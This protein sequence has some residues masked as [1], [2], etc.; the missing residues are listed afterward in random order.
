MFDC[1]PSSLGPRHRHC[2]KFPLATC[3]WAN[4]VQAGGRWLSVKYFMELYR[5]ICPSYCVMLLTMH[6]TFLRN[7]CT[8]NNSSMYVTTFNCR[9]LLLGPHYRHCC[10]FSLAACIWANRDDDEAGGH[11]L[12]NSWCDICPTNCSCCWLTSHQQ[13]CP[14]VAL[15][16]VV[17]TFVHHVSSLSQTGHLLQPDSCSGSLSDYITAASL[18]PLFHYKL[19]RT[20]FDSHT[21]TLLLHH[22]C[23]LTFLSNLGHYK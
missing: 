18:L 8:V 1:L 17:L 5:D 9:P 23:W 6:S 12:L 16:S 20:C 7:S 21:Q 11:S 4:T 22:S 2:C 19:R 14:I 3:I 15:Q 13:A 10:Q